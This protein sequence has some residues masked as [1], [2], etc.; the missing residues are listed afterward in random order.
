M[1]NNHQCL[2]NLTPKP[3][4]PI[5]AIKLNNSRLKNIFVALTTTKLALPTNNARVDKSLNSM[6][7]RE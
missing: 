2:K 6:A 1:T 5:H 3:P 4:P 7:L